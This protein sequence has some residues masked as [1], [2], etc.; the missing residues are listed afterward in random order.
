MN[1]YDKIPFGIYG[2]NSDPKSPENQNDHFQKGFILGQTTEDPIKEVGIEIKKTGFEGIDSRSFIEWKRGLWVSFMKK[3]VERY[4]FKHG[5]VE[6]FQKKEI[7][8]G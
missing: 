1:P 3:I 8:N 7:K 2:V 6:R 5:L 4:Q